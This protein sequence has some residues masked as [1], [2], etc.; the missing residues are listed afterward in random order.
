FVLDEILT[1]R[2]RPGDLAVYSCMLLVALITG[3]IMTY[4]MNRSLRGSY[5]QER[6]IEAQQKMIEH[7][8]ERAD[9]LLYNLLPAPIPERLKKDPARIAERFEQ[10]TV[11]FGD[12]AGF[13]PMS[14]EMSPEDLVAALDEVFTAFDDIAH[15]HGLEKIKTIG[16]AYMAVGGVPTPRE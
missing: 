16:D 6:I 5:R 10:V 14:A 2:S 1:A 12:I 9:S 11:L 8:R 15:R 7:E 4:A 13:T 3:L